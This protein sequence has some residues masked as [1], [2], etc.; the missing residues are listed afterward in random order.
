MTLPNRETEQQFFTFVDLADDCF[1]CWI[2]APHLRRSLEQ[3]KA[4]SQ[5][6]MTEL[7]SAKA[8]VFYWHQN[9]QQQPKG[10]PR[11]HL[12]AYLQESCYWSAYKLSS[13]FS[14][15][16]LSLADC[17]QIAFAKSDR[18]LERFNPQLGNALSTYA[19]SVFSNAVRDAFSDSNEVQIASELSLLRRCAQKHLDGALSD[20]G[21]SKA[22]QVNYKAAW[23]SFKR[24]YFP[25][26]HRARNLVSLV[27]EDWAA[28]AA[29]YNSLRQ[30]NERLSA[31]CPAQLKQWL[32][33]C[34]TY[35]R[36][37]KRPH[38]TSFQAELNPGELLLQQREEPT[39]GP[40]ALLMAQEAEVARQRQRERVTELLVEKLSQFSVHNQTLL[41]LYYSDQLTQTEIA[42]QLNAKQSTISRQLSRARQA[43]L[44]VLVTWGKEELHISFD[45]TVLNNMSSLLEGWLE[46]QFSGERKNHV[47]L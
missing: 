14:T 10:L 46:A 21:L 47:A 32:E 20:A 35:L 1:R 8:W 2:E 3:Q 12:H 15:S 16:Q 7:L 23:L 6:R 19:S 39:A 30:A 36:R 33:D 26:S 18:V 38:T 24:S 41:K 27:E 9:W 37:Y 45:S 29:E 31:S 34:V 25:P 42:A 17:F 22:M 5:Q 11:Q 13:R 40:L 28:I 43:L 4:R 44:A